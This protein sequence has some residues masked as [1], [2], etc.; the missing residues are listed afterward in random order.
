MG[1]LSTAGALWHTAGRVSGLEV[2][3]YVMG[4]NANHQFTVPCLVGKRPIE[5]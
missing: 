3:K 4:R 5:P 1:H 2:G